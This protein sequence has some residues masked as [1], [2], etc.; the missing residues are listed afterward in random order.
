M[1]FSIQQIL[2]SANTIA[3]LGASRDKNKDSFKVMQYLQE[4]GYKVKKTEDLIPTLKQ[5]IIDNTVVI[6][7]CPVDYGENMKLTE[8]LGNL[9][10]PI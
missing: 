9:V 2:N 7:D 3:I 1:N 6:V 8:K 10:S 4:Q 5:A